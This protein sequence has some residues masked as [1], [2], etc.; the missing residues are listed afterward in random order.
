ERA[1]RAPMQELAAARLFRPLGMARAIYAE[2]PDPRPTSAVTGYAVRG[3]AAAPL[4][5]GPS[6][7]VYASVEDLLRW[8]ENVYA[9]AVGGAPRRAGH[10][11][12]R[13]AGWGSTPT[14]CAGSRGVSRP[15]APRCACGSTVSG[16]SSPSPARSTAP[17]TAPS[18]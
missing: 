3:G 5:L 6:S 17:A 7:T 4:E 2:R 16:P 1:A 13:R 12:T 18:S 9:G 15:R 8:A 14:R 11:L 10:R